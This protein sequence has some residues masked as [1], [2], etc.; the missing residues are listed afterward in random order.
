MNG[1]VIFLGCINFNSSIAGAARVRMY[2]K[3]LQAEGVEVKFYSIFDFNQNKPSFDFLNKKNVSFISYPLKILLYV[4]SV[5][6]FIKSD[7]DIVFYLY[8]NGQVLLDYLLIFY[9][10]MLKK[11]KIFLEI[12][13]I[14][15]FGSNIETRSVKYFKYILHEHL[16]KYFN[17]LVCISKNIEMYYRKYNNNTLLVPILSDTGNVYKDNCSYQKGETFNICFTGS[18]HAEKENLAIFFSALRTTVKKGYP[19]IFNLYGP[20][21]YENEF[22]KLVDR[23]ALSRVVKYHGVVEQKL[24]LDIFSKQDLLVLP[25]AQSKQNK[26]GFSTKLSEYLVSG[27][28]TLIT[29]VSDN[30]FYLTPGKDC[31]LADYSN[32]ENFAQQIENLINNYDLLASNLAMNA[33]KTAKRSFGY[34]IH[35]NSFKVFLGFSMQDSVKK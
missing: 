12:N 16:A 22:Y 26:Y 5:K 24:L 28:P 33:L 31:L 8:P 15:R 32:P 34:L 27:V 4:L 13:E 3:M 19:I 35:A 25:R 10:K 21:S 7:S 1:K 6:K 30:L 9:L 2:S 18:V 14:R 11:Q 29:D 20:I 23:Y 17:G